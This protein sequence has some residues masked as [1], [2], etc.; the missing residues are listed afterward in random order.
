[1]IKQNIVSYCK[2]GINIQ[3]YYNILHK[4]KQVIMYNLYMLSCNNI[5]SCTLSL[6]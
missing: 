2:K 1:M 6:R 4:K 5:F 3:F